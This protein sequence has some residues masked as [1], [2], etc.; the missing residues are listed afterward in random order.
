MMKTNEVRSFA[1]RHVPRFHMLE[2]G[3][4][5]VMIGAMWALA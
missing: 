1:R 3:F 5:L 4:F 2:V